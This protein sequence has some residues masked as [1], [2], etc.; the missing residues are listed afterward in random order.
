MLE[1]KRKKY[2]VGFDLGGTKM[3]ANIF[4]TDFKL[5]GRARKKTQARNGSQSGL[6][7]IVQ[8]I[9]GALA[10]TGL[11][12]DQLAGIGL[13]IPGPLDP[14]RG[15]VIHTPN[16]GWR[17][18]QLRK[19]LEEA[20]HCPVFVINDVDAG[21]YG[22]FRFGAAQGTR[23]A[24]GVFPGT[25][26]GG[27]CVYEGRILTGRNR[28]CFEIGHIQLIPDGPLCGCGQRGCLEAVASRLAISASAA[29]AV[30][31]GEA[32][33]LLALA[34]TDLANIRSGALADAIKAGDTVIEE[35]VRNGA[36]WL[37]VGVSTLVNLLA[38][39]VVVLGGG[40][41]E[42]MPAIYVEEVSKIAQARVMTPF[43]DVFKITVSQLGDD[44]VAK[45]AAAWA[46]AC[47]DGK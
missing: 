10:E 40:L 19:P 26:I 22:E 17:N 16:L 29:S 47:V 46:E 35:I 11:Q 31:R 24:V 23:C 37:G 7:R 33:N 38:P 39:D 28:S 45:G 25:G 18:F 34:G 15:L 32:P 14:S 44:A 13:G 6:D 36:R 5:L 4:E 2:W 27:G 12:K 43:K 21:I 8:T 9:E 41:V 42:A 30:F 20:F 1:K 3:L